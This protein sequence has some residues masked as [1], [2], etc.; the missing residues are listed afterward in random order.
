MITCALPMGGGANVRSN[1]GPGVSRSTSLAL[2][3]AA[4]PYTELM[5]GSH[6]THYHPL[7]L[8]LLKAAPPG[9][10]H[11]R[12]PD[13][14]L[15]TI[16]TPDTIFSNQAIGRTP[17]RN[18]GIADNQTSS[19]LFFP[20]GHFLHGRLPSEPMLM[21][22]GQRYEVNKDVTEWPPDLDRCWC[23]WLAPSRSGTNTVSLL[24][25]PRRTP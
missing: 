13:Q 22:N 15:W 18:M 1:A 5:G 9:L 11:L 25:L 19:A 2:F 3:R 7:L 8:T 17:S 6:P 23:T 12:S 14:W 24:T 20:P 10:Q 16:L 21:W 4:L